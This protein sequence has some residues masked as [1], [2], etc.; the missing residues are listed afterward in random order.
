MFKILLII[1]LF[2]SESNNQLADTTIVLKAVSVEAYLLS[3]PLRTIPGS[4]SVLTG[5]RLNLADGT[6]LSGI[7]N[8]LP[9]IS[10]Q[11]GTYAT[12][13]IVIRG[14]GSR[15]PYNS[16]RIRAYLN[17]IPLTSSDGISTPEEIDLQGLGRLEVIKGPAS[18]LYGSGLG[19]S[20]NMYTPDQEH[21]QGNLGIQYGDFSTVKAQVSGTVRTGNYHLW[22]NLSRLQSDGYREDNRYKRS[23]LLMVSEWQHKRG[24]IQATLLLIDVIGGI[25][26]SVGKTMFENNPQAAADN[27]MAIGGYKKYR[28]GLTGITLANKLSE[29]V[30]NQITLFGKWNDNYE[31]RPFNN[32][33][34]RSLSAGIRNKLTFHTTKTDWVLGAEWSAEQYEWKLDKNEIL[35]NE[36]RENRSQLNIFAMSYYRPTEKLNISVAAAINRVGYRLTDLYTLNGDQSGKHQFPVIVSPRIGINYAPN[37]HLALYASAGKG[38]S[39]PSPEETLLPAGEVNP[40]IKP[41]QGAQY[42]VGT[43]LNLLGN[44][45]GLDIGLY[46]IEL[47]NLLITKRITED[48]F[49]GINAGRTRHQ[50]IELLLISRLFRWDVFPGELESTFSYTRSINRFID[51]TD[52]GNTYNGNLLPGIPDHYGQLL[53]VWKPFKI[54]EVQAQLQYTGDQYLNDSNSLSYP[55]YLLSNLKVS[56]RVPLKKTGTIHIYAGINNLGDTRY[57]SMLIINAIGFGATEPRYYYP[58]LPRHGYIGIQF[59]IRQA[60]EQRKSIQP[61]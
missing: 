15:T 60:D 26:S 59:L 13:R 9:G 42:E 52:D 32:L 33:D 17:D 5:E 12:S 58:G 34:D 55:G 61:T 19:G 25:P 43:R 2:S 28:K 54:L 10:M 11:S 30:V 37:N 36:N 44:R 57:A 50:G 21:N 51:F 4:L 29:R 53:L 20:I 46:R 48:L 38:H 56:T 41:E 24:S 8:T 18:A 31:K 1:L 47:K 14:M 16:N 40:D 27:W 23:S 49:T 45:I 35:L 22:G 7:L 6:S 3:G 39:H